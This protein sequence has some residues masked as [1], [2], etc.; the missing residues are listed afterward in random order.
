MQKEEDRMKIAIQNELKNAIQYAEKARGAMNDIGRNDIAE[1]INEMMKYAREQKFVVGVV[2]SAKRG[3][4][5][6]INGLLGR[7]NDKM[8]PI[9]KFPTTNVISIFKN[10]DKI[11]IKIFFHGQKEYIDVS[12]DEVRLYACEDHNPEN[13]KN[14]R[15]IEAEGP[16][17]GLDDN[18]YVVDTPGANNALAAM[19]SEILLNFL[20]YA[21]ALIFLVTAGEPLVKAES[22]LLRDI[23]EK[24]IKKIFFAINKVDRVD[25]EELAEGIE[26]NREILA[27]IGFDG[28]KIYTISAKEYFE[29]S[30]NAGMEDLIDAIRQTIKNDRV[31]I[32]TER[33]NERTRALLEQTQIELVNELQQAKAS[34]QD[35]KAEKM[36]LE[37]SKREL[38]RGRSSRENKFI[39]EWDEAFSDLESKIRGIRNDLKIEYEQLID[40]ASA[41]GL[42]ALAQAIHGRIEVSFSEKIRPIIDV[43]ERRLDQAQKDFVEAIQTTIIT[44]TP[45]VA[46]SSTAKSDVLGGFK[47]LIAT[48]PSIAVGAFS[49]SLPGL[50]GGAVIG[51]APIV[52]APVWYNPFTWIASAATGA[53][54][55]GIT[56]VG[57]G[58]T[59]LLTTVCIPLSLAAFGYAAYRGYSTFREQRNLDKNKLKTSID[60]MIDEGC[61]SVLE[62]FQAAKKQIKPILNKINSDLDQKLA[63]MD[64]RLEELIR[65][66][67]SPDKI[68]NLEQNLKKQI[69]LLAAPKNDNMEQK[70]PVEPMADDLFK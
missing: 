57:A 52:T 48:I 47:P 50:I 6:L 66:R 44:I 58:I 43:C 51:S 55:A 64:Y 33:I 27:D 62:Q 9:G 68:E 31:K 59:G 4:S 61:T 5:T 18:V 21:D 1:E 24:D 23:K 42:N 37:K 41:A 20:P 29:K 53:A 15:S 56:T 13:K 65:N 39:R 12:E 3:K 28:V 2:G 69:L 7:K 38:E 46:P 67:P 36:Q 54:S 19:H 70:H 11:S 10:A 8:A 45:D 34:D 25:E 16:F 30:S 26:H 14:V 49:S 40:K 32:I 63:D 35:L 17:P 22:D 60:R